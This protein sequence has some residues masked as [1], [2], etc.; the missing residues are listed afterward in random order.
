MDLRLVNLS[1]CAKQL[2]CNRSTREHGLQEGRWILLMV[3]EGLAPGYLVS[4]MWTEHQSCQNSEKSGDM[5]R[6]QGTTAPRARPGDPTSS[7]W[8]PQLHNKTTSWSPRVGNTSLW[9]QVWGRGGWVSISYS[10]HNTI[11]LRLNDRNGLLGGLPVYPQF[12]I[13]PSGS[14]WQ[15]G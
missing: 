1:L 10:G 3:S 2:P 11:C 15:V 13:F 4:C 12:I 14:K 6:R 7:R 5:G 8:F 9:Q